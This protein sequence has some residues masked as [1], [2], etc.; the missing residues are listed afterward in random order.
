MRDR[1]NN[2]V[3][4]NLTEDVGKSKEKELL[5]KLL[6][7]VTGRKIEKE[8]LEMFRIGKKVE[9]SSKSLVDKIWKLGGQEHGSGQQQ[10][11][12]R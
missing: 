1:Q 11:V 2:T 5:S 4:C 6:K 10:K 8:I 7:E 9:E 12:E 3:V